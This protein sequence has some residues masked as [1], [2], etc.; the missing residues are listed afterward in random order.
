MLECQCEAAAKQE[1]REA[2]QER[3]VANKKCAASHRNNCLSTNNDRSEKR[4]QTENL[5]HHFKPKV[6]TLHGVHAL[7][8]I[9]DI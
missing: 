7:V 5:C 2:N 6:M 8:I 3:D 9:L 1:H 4:G